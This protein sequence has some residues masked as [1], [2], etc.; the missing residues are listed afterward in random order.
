MILPSHH[1][2]HLISTMAAPVAMLFIAT[3]FNFAFSD[4]ACVTE[5]GAPPPKGVPSPPQTV[6]LAAFAA[7]AIIS[8]AKAAK[9]HV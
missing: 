2:Y 4:G 8:Y 7:S 6:A 9:W 3:Y 1:H 5:E